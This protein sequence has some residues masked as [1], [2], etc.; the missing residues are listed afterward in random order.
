MAPHATSLHNA[1]HNSTTPHHI[2]LHP[3]DVNTPKHNP[4]HHTCTLSALESELEAMRVAAAAEAA[5]AEKRTNKAED[6]IASLSM[7]KAKLQSE[8][9]ALREESKSINSTPTPDVADD[10]SLAD[11]RNTIEQLRDELESKMQ[12]LSAQEEELAETHR[13]LSAQDEELA[14][15]R[16]QL[17][18]KVLNDPHCAPSSSCYYKF[19]HFF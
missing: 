13:H 7:A 3:H 1:Q 9:A 2:K 4:P 5:D 17:S 14:E 12:E 16:R 15:A 8:I 18:V 11:A 19:S 6:A 10:E